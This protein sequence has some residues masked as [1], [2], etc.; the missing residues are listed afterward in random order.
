M[1][2]T[3]KE[4]KNN[5]QA[6]NIP[7]AMLSKFSTR[8]RQGFYL[9]GKNTKKHATSATKMPKSGRTYIISTG[10]GR[11]THIS[12]SEGE[13]HANITRALTKSIDFKVNGYKSMDFGYDMSTKYGKFVEL[14]TAK[15]KPR[16]TLKNAMKSAKTEN[17]AILS[18]SFKPVNMLQ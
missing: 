1:Y 8:V 4:G 16:P 11:K 2:I 5:S 12:S 10:K 3:L 14:G 17:Q 15:M 6:F 18:N 13:S 9:I 7:N